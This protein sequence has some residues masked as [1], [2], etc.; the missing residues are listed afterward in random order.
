MRLQGFGVIFA[1]IVVPII[2][3]LSYYLSLQIKTITRQSEYDSA[4]LDA[5]YDAM[6]SFEI[7]T[8]NEDLSTVSDSLRTIIEASCNVFTNTLA[9]NL[10]MSNASKSYLEPFLPAVLYTLYD[11]YYIYSP[12]NVPDIV[13]DKD[14]NAV[15]VGDKGVTGS[16]GSYYYDQALDARVSYDE[17]NIDENY[18]LQLYYKKDSD[19]PNYETKTKTERRLYSRCK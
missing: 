11:G 9:T 4:L 7:N 15:C 8:A 2:L 16:N 1:V 14:G 10:G 19:N 12:T 13:V 18:G 3:V 6:T 17:N 5:T